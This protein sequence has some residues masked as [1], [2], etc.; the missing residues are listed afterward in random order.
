MSSSKYDIEVDLNREGTSHRL[1]VDFI[2]AN[3]TVLDVG[4]SS[5]YLS[6]VLQAAGN[7]VS[8]VEFDP[9]A[10]AIAAPVLEKVVVADLEK[11][12]LAEAFAGDTFEVIVFGDVLEHL[13]DPLSTLRQARRLLAPQ[14]Y[15]VISIPNIAHGDVRMSLLLGR[16]EYRNLGLLDNTH[17]HFVTRATLRELLRDAGFVATDVQV[18]HA[19]LFG[20][21]LGVRPEEVPDD[22]RELIAADPDSTTYQFVLTA[23]R[24]DAAHLQEGVAWDLA[25]AR[26][27]VAELREQRDLAVRLQ[28]AVDREHAEIGRLNTVLAQVTAEVDGLRTALADAERRASLLETA[29]NVLGAA[30][31]DA[32]ATAGTAAADLSAL[33]ATRTLKLRARVLRWLGR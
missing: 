1:M 24:D 13:R 6:K 30:L 17:V 25:E 16:F 20:T 5:G 21:E 8:G 27:E 19:P 18:T 7:R 9:E 15:I 11:T 23:V 28:T 26:R 32:R 14:G 31:E 33:T 2:G 29:N 22:V 10:A 12:D 3:K 4:C